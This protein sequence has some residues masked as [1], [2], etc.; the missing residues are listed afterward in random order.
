MNIKIFCRC[1]LFPSWSGTDLSARAKDLSAPVYKA[2]SRQLPEW[3]AVSR[4][5]IERADLKAD[6]R[7]RDL[8]NTNQER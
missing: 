4:E 3:T 8:P 6:I 1:S 2:F 5:E 7:T